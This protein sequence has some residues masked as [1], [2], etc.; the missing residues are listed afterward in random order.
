MEL[1]YKDCPPDADGEGK[2]A[3]FKKALDEA[4]EQ[5][6]D[7][8]YSAKYKGSGKAIYQVALAL[9]GRGEIEMRVEEQ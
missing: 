1:K 3:L 2:R 6:S 4:M 9:L 5:I 8:G 7:R